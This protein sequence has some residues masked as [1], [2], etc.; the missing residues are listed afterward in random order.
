M[1]IVPG[2]AFFTSNLMKIQWIA[3]LAATAF[4]LS[5]FA[6]I[7]GTFVA[8]QDDINSFQSVD[9]TSVF[10]DADRT[11][12][13]W[14]ERPGVFNIESITPSGAYQG[15]NKVGLT[16]NPTS[17]EV[18]TTLTGL[19]ADTSYDI[20]MIM[21]VNSGGS[22]GAQNIDAGF[23]SGA[24]STFTEANATGTGLALGAGGTWSAAES[25]IGSAVADGSGEIKV[26]VNATA[27]AE[28]SVYNGLS[29]IETPPP[30]PIGHYW[31]FTVNLIDFPLV[32][33][34]LVGDLD[35]NEEGF[36]DVAV[37]PTYGEAFSG[38]DT[39]LNTLRDDFNYF[40]AET[41]NG[42]ATALDFGSDDFAISYWVYDDGTD[43]D[44]GGVDEDLRG[45]RVLDCADS[46]NGGI[47][48]TVTPDAYFSLRV[49]DLDGNQSVSHQQAGTVFE[50][51]AFPTDAWVQVSI[52]VDRGNDLITVYF[53]GVS[54]GSYDISNLTGD[55]ACSQDLEVGVINGGGDGNGAQKSGLDEL[56]FY[57]A[58]LTPAD[59]AGLAGATTSPADIMGAA[60]VDPPTISSI[61]YDP[62]TG[63]ATITFPTTIGDTYT[64]EGSG[65][66]AAWLPLD[67]TDT[68]PIDGTGGD[69]IFKHVSGQSPYFYRLIRN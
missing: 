29:Y 9:G 41:F 31:D 35:L 51:L 34:D 14:H 65:N 8:A 63:T 45:A 50:T 3:A 22:S 43:N 32:V 36:A 59:V 53:D 6:Q 1:V 67:N 37:D 58:L 56:A 40:I 30:P 28:R 61:S 49:D 46:T 18:V 11:L 68:T 33:Y 64:V 7:T 47:E 44:P 60:P 25:L 4:P 12:D 24:L 54:Q 52:N 48:I 39:S 55:I 13:L 57:P 42:T 19:T 21:G 27:G 2:K 23:V 5:A 66:L 10:S 38:S 15:Q 16:P 69:V 20:Y 17:N 26:Y 62:G